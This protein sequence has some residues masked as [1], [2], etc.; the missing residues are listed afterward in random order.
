[1]IDKTKAIQAKIV[2]QHYLDSRKLVGNLDILLEVT[3]Q[4]LSAE[5]AT[6]FFNVRTLQQKY[7]DVSDESLDQLLERVPVVL[8][9]I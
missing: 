2:V 9:N 7:G 4:P 8:G 3:P 1:M 6:L 5:D